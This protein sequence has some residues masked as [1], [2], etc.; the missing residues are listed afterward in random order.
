[1]SN[2]T[3]LIVDAAI[4]VG[5]LAAFEPRL[6]GIAL[7][8]WLSLAVFGV[9][10]AHLALHWRWV[11]QITRRFFQKLF[12]SS[13]LNYVL[14]AA[15]LVAFVAMMLSGVL[16]SRSVLP[17]L[18]LQAVRDQFWRVLHTVSANASLALVAAHVALHW[19]WI[20]NALKR[21]VLS[22]ATRLFRRPVP[23]RR[24]PLMA[25][26]QDVQAR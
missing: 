3:N 1:M 12:H 4:F 18:G 7:H 22:P 2:K 16:I 15:L 10:V 8:E 26:P 21:Y 24:A 9:I 19:E 17:F 13:R 11:V 20:V 14:N 6:T 5:F 25:Q 23:A